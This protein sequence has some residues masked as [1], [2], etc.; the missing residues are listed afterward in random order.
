MHGPSRAFMLR[1]LFWE[2]SLYME[3]VSVTREANTPS[4]TWITRVCT[5][6]STSQW[7]L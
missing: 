5:I 2:L 3:V 6:S 1:S 7:W 4:L